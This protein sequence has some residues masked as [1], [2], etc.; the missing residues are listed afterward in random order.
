MIIILS[1]TGHRPNDL[2]GFRSE[3]WLTL[4][5]LAKTKIA[6]L[7]PVEVWTGGAL[8][9]DQACCEACIQLDIPFTLVIPCL[10]WYYASRWSD[11]SQNYF[12]GL[13][14][15]S[16]KTGRRHAERLMVFGTTYEM[17][18]LHARNNY[19]VENCDVL[20]ALY[21]GK[22]S[23]GTANAVNYAGRLRKKVINA[24]SDYHMPGE[25]P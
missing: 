23:G 9:W 14:D 3:V 19:M 12:H 22:S 13:Y 7:N 21:S 8:G 20:L 4:V 10:P 15:G 11:Q 6:E 2:G 16:I 25:T 1:V 24:W 17:S 5:E 18:Q